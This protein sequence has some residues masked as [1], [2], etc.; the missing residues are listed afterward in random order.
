MRSKV[1]V[2]SK[3]SMRSKV[4]ETPRGTEWM[5]FADTHL[6]VLVD[7][8]SFVVEKLKEPTRFMSRETRRL[9]G[10][11]LVNCILFVASRVWG[12]YHLG[13]KSCSHRKVCAF[14]LF[15][16]CAEQR[17]LRAGRVT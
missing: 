1:Q 10:E 8:V 5:P 2:D 3:S 9:F 6:S 4:M 16:C 14:H 13:E 17:K 15:Q 12:T 11:I 7:A